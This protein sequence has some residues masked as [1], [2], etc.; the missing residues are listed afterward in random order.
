MTLRPPAI[1]RRQLLRRGGALGAGL[2]GASFLAACSAT[3]GGNAPS[4]PKAGKVTT[5]PARLGAVTLA[6]WDRF[7]KEAFP[8]RYAALEQLRSEFQRKYPNIKITRVAKTTSELANIK[9]SLASSD[10][11]PDVFALNN[12]GYSAAPLVKAGLL[13]NLD[14]YYT[15]YGWRKRIPA[16]L[17]AEGRYRAT[18]HWGDRAGHLYGSGLFLSYQL[19][20]YNKADVDKLGGLPKTFADLEPYLAKAKQR[21][22]TPFMIGLGSPQN[23]SHSGI[24]LAA[25]LIME[26]W[27]ADN[28][29]R[30]VYGQPGISLD[31]PEVIE[32]LT[33][34]QKWGRQGYF[35]A[36]PA[37]LD[38]SSDVVT[39]FAKGTGVFHYNGMWL[40]PKIA[41]TMGDNFGQALPPGTHDGAS[42][43]TIAT[44]A[45]LL[46]SAKT[47]HPDAVGAW[48]D[49]LISPRAA[50]IFL[51]HGV[52]PSTF[53][54]PAD[55]PDEATKQSAQL[56]QKAFTS[57]NTASNLQGAWPTGAAD[58]D[59]EL[60]L[61][62][63][64]RKTPQQVAQ[65][66]DTY[67]KEF[68]SQL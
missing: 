51:S 35:P 4:Q 5:D 24:Y 1:T 57:G 40:N 59:A 43:P 15:A 67:R 55:A 38:P 30:W 64:G 36:N 28:L 65:A 17:D 42:G 46:A 50:T 31:T 25:L 61:L 11:G 9:L 45:Q 21:G 54:N 62:L 41:P 53:V 47:K 12:T 16:S 8:T 68:L 52:L 13:L 19:L 37:G 22:Y 63:A 32:A 14:P 27:G 2:A 23:G 6:Q 39:S 20:Q 60:T 66:F 10:G 56:A 18:G 29:R 3:P 7:T 26:K 58:Q 49:F 33:T 44:S 34:F 48:L